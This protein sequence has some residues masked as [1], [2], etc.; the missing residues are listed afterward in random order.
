MRILLS[1]YSCKPDRGSEP[2]VGWGW[3]SALADAGHTVD[4]LTQASNRVS[5]EA[6]L[7]AR[8]RP[9]LRFHWHE[10]SPLARRLKKSGGGL[11]QR[12]YYIAWQKSA[13]PVLRRIAVERHCELGHHVTFAQYWSFCALSQ[14]GLPFIW[15][16]VGG[17]ERTPPAFWPQLGA[18]ACLY[19]A[20]RALL[21]RV[22]A[23][24][25]FM[26]ATARGCRLAVASTP[27]TAARLSALGVARPLT[28]SQV[29]LKPA[30]L[31]RLALMTPLPA[32]QGP[33]RFVI[34]GDLLAHKGVHLALEA[35]ARLNGDW[36]LAVIGDGPCR[37]WLDAQARR[38]GIA[39]RVHFHGAL[40]RLQAWRQLG[41]AQALLFPALHDSGGMA[42]AEAMAAGLPVICLALGGPAALVV[43]GTGFAVPAP[44]PVTAVAGLVLAAQKLI[45][46]PDL[47]AVLSAGAR[48]HAQRSFTW[49]ARVAAVYGAL[50]VSP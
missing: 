34:L 46:E 9:L 39:E 17:G 38:L 42:V 16:P 8:P 12:L 31:A 47:W 43:D 26:R 23:W 35:L 3:A 29:A 20:A 7:A 14:A 1:A 28:V 49:P 30:D 32:G 5:I 44:D 33:F 22:S 24:G 15:G 36:T 41:E 48:A 25:G 13:V 18:R 10:L 27:E 6:E 40:P 4:I 2:G 11:G 45:D 21:G 50:E 19:E 37:Q